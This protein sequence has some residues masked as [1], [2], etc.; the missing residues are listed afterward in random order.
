MRSF[1]PD[2]SYTTEVCR[3]AAAILAEQGIDAEIVDMMSLSLIDE[4][5]VLES[6]I[7]TTGL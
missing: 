6:V 4:D 1:V 5:I 7:K 2:E 3:L